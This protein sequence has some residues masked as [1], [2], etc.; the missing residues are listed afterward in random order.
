[1]NTTI[2]FR[3]L[4]GCVD[5]VTSGPEFALETF[6]FCLRVVVVV[7]RVCELVVL[8]FLR[9]GACGVRR[10]LNESAVMPEEDVVDMDKTYLSGG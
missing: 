10:K 4:L 7:L 9:T 2:P 6:S 1:M 3:M 8:G 5:S